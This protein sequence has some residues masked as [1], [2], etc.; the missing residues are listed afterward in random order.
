MVTSVTVV[1]IIVIIVAVMVTVMFLM[2]FLVMFLVLVMVLM[3]ARRF[4]KAAAMAFVMMA[5]PSVII[6]RAVGD[7]IS[8]TAVGGDCDITVIP[9]H[10]HEYLWFLRARRRQLRHRGGKQHHQNRC[11]D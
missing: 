1:V 6:P 4:Y 10:T 3:S 9:G 5:A 7:I 11:N 2:M 8:H